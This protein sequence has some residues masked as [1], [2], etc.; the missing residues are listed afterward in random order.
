MQYTIKKKGKMFIVKEYMTSNQYSV[1]S[2]NRNANITS[3][4]FGITNIA[5]YFPLIICAFSAL[6]YGVDVVRVGLWTAEQ[7][8]SST[9]YFMQVRYN[10]ADSTTTLSDYGNVTILWAR[11]D[12]VT[13]IPYSE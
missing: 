11:N 6:K 7:A 2:S 1:T 4:S 10:G 8:G 9:E 12:L 13:V 5:G 3:S